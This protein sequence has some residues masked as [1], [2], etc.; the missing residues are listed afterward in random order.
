MLNENPSR[1]HQFPYLG[2]SFLK[3]SALQTLPTDNQLTH[4]SL[5]STTSDDIQLISSSD[6]SGVK[7]NANNQT[8]AVN[9]RT[10]K[11]SRCFGNTLCMPQNLLCF[12]VR[13]STNFCNLVF[14]F[15]NFYLIIFFLFSSLTSYKTKYTK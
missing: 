15:W 12:K 6:K 4:T 7:F 11:V 8:I 1:I 5:S 10:S 9:C 13:L 2:I 3:C 14:S